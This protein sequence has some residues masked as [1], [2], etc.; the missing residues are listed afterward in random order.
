[1]NNNKTA[2]QK[3]ELIV[4]LY[5]LDEILEIMGYYEGVGSTAWD[6]KIQV[7]LEELE[8]TDFNK[9]T[10]IVLSHAIINGNFEEALQYGK[11]LSI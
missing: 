7:E 8:D 6:E 5:T 2:E 10:D 3:K 4:K 1:M 9:F 11:K